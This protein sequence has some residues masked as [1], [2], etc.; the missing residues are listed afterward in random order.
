MT[1][2]SSLNLGPR[3][4]SARGLLAGFAA[5]LALFILLT[6]LYGIVMVYTPMPRWDDWVEVTAAQQLHRSFIQ[7]NEHRLVTSRLFFAMD[8]LLFRGRS[9]FSLAVMLVVQGL[10]AW[11]L[12]YVLGR[13]TK[14]GMAEKVAAAALAVS[15]LFWL[16]QHETLTW[17]FNLHFVLLY[18]LT[19]A[20]F[21]ALAFVPGFRGLLVAAVC[22]VLAALTMVNGTMVPFLLVSLAVWLGRPRLQTAAL[23]AVAVITLALYLYGYQLPSKTPDGTTLTFAGKLMRYA[24]IFLG[25]PFEQSVRSLYAWLDAKWLHRRTMALVVGGI[26]LVLFAGL[27]VRLL[28][29]GN[30]AR[31][32]RFVLFHISAFVVLTAFL[33]ARGRAQFGLEQ[34]LASRYSTAAVIFWLAA[35]F[36]LWSMS[37]GRAA[38]NAILAGTTMLALFAA[39]TQWPLLKFIEKNALSQREK[40]ALV[41][42]GITNP[43]KQQHVFPSL[44]LLKSQIEIMRKRHISIFASPWT[45]WLGSPLETRVTHAPDGACIGYLDEIT[46]LVS[47]ESGEW[48]ARG[49]AW[50]RASR[51]VPEAV[52]L[53]QEDGTIVGYGLSGWERRDLARPFPGISYRRAGWVGYFA[54]TGPTNIYAYALVRGGEAV[55]PLKASKASTDGTWYAGPAESR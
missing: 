32:A 45:H 31:P 16:V 52:I 40:E 25:A 51:G 27:G 36:L 33:T 30:A 15:M 54:V 3:L 8:E 17:G 5:V 23:A 43:Q 10:H 42:S 41:L 53:T 48:R 39:C 19:S 20:S 14:L 7:H 46:P 18:A 47:G 29:S 4:M 38:R 44:P 21:A 12:V 22:A 11:L 49:W 50:D 9:Q 55:C 37:N 6:T 34:A 2:F 24:S 26:G 1:R 13:A 35:L 28:L